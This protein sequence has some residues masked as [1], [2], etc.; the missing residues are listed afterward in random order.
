M[1]HRDLDR[2]NNSSEYAD[3][4]IT[5]C[6]HPFDTVDTTHISLCDRRW[7]HCRHG[8]QATVVV[9]PSTTTGMCDY[10]CGPSPRLLPDRQDRQ[11]WRR[12]GAM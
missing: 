2:R 8:P 12:F 9:E 6:R 7:S 1:K 10:S 3:L 5:H 11:N 4:W